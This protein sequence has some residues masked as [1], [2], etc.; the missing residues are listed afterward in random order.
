MSQTKIALHRLHSIPGASYV[1]FGVP[2][3]KGEVKR[4]DTWNLE[5]ETARTLPLQSSVRAYWPDGSVKWTLHTADLTNSAS[6]RMF[7]SQ[8]HRSPSLDRDSDENTK[9]DDGPDRLFI[10]LGSLRVLFTKDG[11]CVPSVS[12]QDREYIRRGSLTVQISHHRQQGTRTVSDIMPYFGTADTYTV[13]EAGPLRAVVKL[14]GIHV[15]EETGCP[16]F[17]GQA[18]PF[19]LRYYLYRDSDKLRI[20]H[21]FCYD[22]DHRTDFI[23][24]VG[25][26]FD[27]PV[28]GPIYNRKVRIAGDGGLQKESCVLLKSWHPA[29]PED[30]YRAQIDGENLS[31]DP[32]RDPDPFKAMDNMNF[33]DGYQLIQDSSEHFR[34]RKTTGAPDCAPVDS[35]EGNRSMGYLYAGDENQGLGI[36]MKDFWQ[37]YPSGLEVS[38]LLTDEA[39]YNAWF[40][41]PYGEAMDL[42]FYDTKGCSQAYYG[43]GDITRS[44]PYG[45]AVTNELTL[46]F[47]HGSCPA[48]RELLTRAKLAQTP[49]LLVCEPSYYHDVR[50]FGR[51][52]LPDRSTPSKQWLEQC[53]DQAVGFYQNEIEARKWYGLW[54]YGDVMHSYDSTR[55]CWRYDLGGWAWQNTELVPTLWLWYSFLRTGRPDIFLMAEAMCRHTRDVDVLHMGE[56]KGLGSRHNVKHWGGSAKEARISMCGHHRFYYYLTGD[57]RTGDV[58]DEVKDVDFTTIHADPLRNHYEK[59]PNAPYPTHARSGPDWS[60]YCFNW[61]T[62][63]ERFE[64]QKYA[65]K[66]RTGVHCLSQAPYRLIS[67]VDFGYDP[68][69]GRLYYIGEQS[70]G[71]SHLAA[72]MG[73]PQLYVEL[74]DVLEDPV[75]EEMLVEYG[76]FYYLSP[77][78]KAAATNDVVGYKDWSFP[79]AAATLVSFAAEKKKD[80]ALG[81][82][83]WE[84]LTKDRKKYPFSYE[85]LADAPA[86]SVKKEIPWISTNSVSQWCLNVITSLDMA[87]EYLPEDPDSI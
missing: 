53:L 71:G 39:R 54:N 76:S 33:W 18:L 84:I 51:W 22:M 73:G 36:G 3:A 13:E 25:M 45:I 42:R 23:Q 40:W 47:Y 16:D 79:S 67:G 46:D 83:I 41:T 32:A 28:Q 6:D 30:L 35:L 63:W 72:C 43:A 38:G 37:K 70:T 55:H 27:A 81:R 1:T 21:T 48:D 19:T 15:P 17:R 78:E 65:D 66:L 14:S 68:E 74:A 77:E 8:D 52:S 56:F 82:R 7:L 57:E 86:G 50:A 87:G 44:T 61:F 4:T 34:V 60:S 26:Q 20:M 58:L 24:S 9:I 69:S 12:F 75:W 80:E 64:D 59:D 31:L 85:N 11:S 49:E 29:L 62:R 5:D 10:R 2:W